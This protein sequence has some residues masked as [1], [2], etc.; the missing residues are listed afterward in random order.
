VRVLFVSNGFPPSGQW[1]TEFYTHQLATGLARRGHDVSVLHPVR[2]GSRARYTLETRTID[3][4]PVTGLHNAGDPL[5]R[6]ADSYENA[7]IERMFADMLARVK[8]DVVHFTHFLWGLSAR[9][10]T[11]A[12]AHGAGVV[13]T[14][15]DYG[16]LCHRGQLF[17]WKLE[18]CSGPG[19]AS[20]CARCVREP[21]QFDDT[22]PR[23]L[24]K[25]TAVR[26]LAAV[27]GLGLVVQEGDIFRR[28][29]VIASVVP[30]VDR[31]ILP[32]RTLF[33]K[34]AAHGFPRERMEVLVYGIDE[35]AFVQ[36][37]RTQPGGSGS[38]DGV[39]R[40]GFM[41]QFTP[42]K[43]LDKLLDAVRLLKRRASESAAS[44]I[45]ELYG[46][47][48]EGRHKRYLDAALLPDVADRVRWMGSFEP[49]AAPR[50]LERLSAVIVPSQWTENAPL[51]VLQA[52]AAG[53]PVIASDVP[54]VREVLDDGVHGILVPRGD[55]RALADAMARFVTQSESRAIPIAPKVLYADHLAR[56]EAIYAEV[57]APALAAVAT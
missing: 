16:L 26:A 55:V 9:L 40:F 19:S 50:I 28:R 12:R 11:L 45:V 5:K 29:D 21:S 53:V 43:G 38:G 27:G 32:T 14:L 54:G 8:P 4:V 35:S 15:T 1:G 42:H 18:P 46:H 30:S 51:T 52:R 49:L 22:T 3:G 13:V 2:D 37:S 23:L 34:F 39:L 24:G 41:G 57:R 33:A 48:S 20:T 6:F 10:P 36:P 31:W 7:R 56:V 25:R 17:D 47:A 44:W